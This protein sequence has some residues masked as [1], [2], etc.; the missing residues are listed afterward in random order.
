MD[1]ISGLGKA[2]DY[3]E[4]HITDDIDYELVAKEAFSSSYHFQRVFGIL[5]GYTLGEYIRQRR[6]SLAGAEL[7]G[8][9]CKVIDIALKYGYDSPDSFT[10]AF[11]AFHG[12]TPSQ[13]R[14]DG[15]ML[16]SFSRL[17]IKISLEGGKTMDYKIIEKGEMILT[18]YKRHFDGVPG[19][20]ED[21][22]F[23]M[24]VNTRPLQ[25]MLKALSGSI[26]TDY[27]V[28]TNINDDGYDFYIASELP[29]AYREN[30]HKTSVLGEEFA[31][32]FEHI[33]IS[34][35]TYAVFET[36]RC[37]Y[38]TTI[39]LDLRKKI[40]NEWLPNSG[41]RLANAPEL[42]VTHWFRGEKSNQRYREL[43]IPIEK[44]K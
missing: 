2:I 22:E 17:S 6:L 9:K 15:S 36:E 10:K 33:T 35:Q 24:Y 21:Q 18:G 3:I 12:I 16:K 27:N 39:F 30:L 43:W 1:W 5:C 32:C 11:R 23:D 29:K 37:S 13:A 31:K 7:A 34:S 26:E 8:G 38:P 14:S 41:Y 19:E 25:Y 44:I 40:A 28:I 20:R 42:V 4:N